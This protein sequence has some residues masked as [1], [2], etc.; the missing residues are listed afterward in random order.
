MER[1][2]PPSTAAGSATSSS[3]GAPEENWRKPP[4]SPY[5]GVTP[6]AAAV[7][8]AVPGLIRDAFPRGREFT[9]I[10]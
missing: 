9:S 8:V 7:I 3:Q 5:D 2:R 1:E 6:T 10:W 4:R